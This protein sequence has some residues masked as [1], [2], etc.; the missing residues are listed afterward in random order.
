MH[1]VGRTAR[2]DTKGLA[3]T[4]VSVP[5]QYNFSEIEQ[6]IGEEIRKIPVPAVL[7]EG[8]E[9]NPKKPKFSG[10]QNRRKR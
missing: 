8:P 9:Y 3:F 2:A 5:E 4:L 1:R 10:Y 7:G 6:L